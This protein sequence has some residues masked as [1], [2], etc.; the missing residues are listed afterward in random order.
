MVYLVHTVI[1]LN[2]QMIILCILPEPYS[3]G[4]KMNKLKCFELFWHVGSCFTFP[5][6]I[7]LMGFSLIVVCN[8]IM[9]YH[10]LYVM[11]SLLLM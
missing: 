1:Y 8:K 11:L 2:I 3:M 7:D 6:F 5:H 9:S 4:D 10:L